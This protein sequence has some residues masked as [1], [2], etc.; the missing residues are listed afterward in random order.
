MARR[1]IAAIDVPSSTVLLPV[2]LHPVRL[3]QRGFNQAERLATVVARRLDL[4]IRTDLLKRIR[5]SSSQ[6]SLEIDERRSAVAGAF[7]L[8]HRP[9]PGPIILVDDVWTTGA[10]AEA[11]LNTLREADVAGPL[12][13]LVAARTPGKP[14]G[15]SHPR[16]CASVTRKIANCDR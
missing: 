4:S 9:S 2:P 5:W 7:R 12:Y 16:P 3:R 8:R 10:T 15:L 1:L 14:S 13:T 11:C 6:T